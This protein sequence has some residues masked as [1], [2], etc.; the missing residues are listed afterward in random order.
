M[1][2][3]VVVAPPTDSLSLFILHANFDKLFRRQNDIDDN[4]QQQ[5][6]QK[7]HFS[8]TLIRLHTHTHTPESLSF[9]YQSIRIAT[10]KRPLPNTTKKTEAY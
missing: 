9:R 3:L 7:K 2:P 10:K 8:C 4:G 1:F 6:H 5:Q